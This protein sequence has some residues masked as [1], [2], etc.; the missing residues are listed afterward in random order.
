MSMGSWALGT[1]MI[2]GTRPVGGGIDLG[3]ANLVVLDSSG[4]SSL[5]LD[6]T[7]PNA[8]LLVLDSDGGTDVVLT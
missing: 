3:D 1:K 5:V 2:G 4:R 6:A 8:N 7:P